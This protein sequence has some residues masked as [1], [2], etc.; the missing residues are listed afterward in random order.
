MNKKNKSAP[1]QRVAV[2]CRVSTDRTENDSAYI[3]QRQ[4]YEKKVPDKKRA[5]M[6][7]KEEFEARFNEN[8]SNLIHR[9]A[10]NMAK[11]DEKGE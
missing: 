8:R 11:Y 9:F 10:D 2:Y 5:L 7:L 1:V 4:F 3:L 6:Q